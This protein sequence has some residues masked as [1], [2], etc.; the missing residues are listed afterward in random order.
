MKEV[1]LYL[2]LPADNLVLTNK[3][4][5]R[6]DTWLT[7]ECARLLSLRRKP[8]I[9]KKDGLISLYVDSPLTVRESAKY[10]KTKPRS[11]MA[12]IENND[13]NYFKLE[14][15]IRIYLRDLDTIKRKNNF[16]P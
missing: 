14:G 3:G 12:L 4:S 15:S 13:L 5:I 2:R 11:I 9:E 6:Y 8:R 1:E 16:L 10:L 7:N